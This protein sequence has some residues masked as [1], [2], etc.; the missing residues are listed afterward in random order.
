MTVGLN[1][2][3]SA[4]ELGY[5]IYRQRFT[6]YFKPKPS[7][8][9]KN[10][11]FRTPPN[12]PRHEIS[13]SFTVS[14][15][16][17]EKWFVYYVEAIAQFSKH[18]GLS[19]KLCSKLLV[20]SARLCR[21]IQVSSTAR[22]GDLLYQ[23]FVLSYIVSFQSLHHSEIPLERWSK[24]SSYPT[25]TLAKMLM[26]FTR[27][28]TEKDLV[29]VATM[30]H[31]PTLLD[32]RKNYKTLH[33][34]NVNG[35]IIRGSVQKPVVNF[36]Y[37]FAGTVVYLFACRF[38]PIHSKFFMEKIVPLKVIESQPPAFELVLP[39]AK[40]K[41]WYPCFLGMVFKCLWNIQ[42]EPH[43]VLFA[44]LYVGRYL[45][46]VGNFIQQGRHQLLYQ[47]FVSA[48]L[49]AQNTFGQ[50]SPIFS[51]WSAHTGYTMEDLQRMEIA[52]LN[53]LNWWTGVE[54]VEYQAF[55]T[56][57][58]LFKYF[59]LS[60]AEETLVDPSKLEYL[61]TVAQ[62]HELNLLD[63]VENHLAKNF[64]ASPLEIPIDEVRNIA[65]I[66]HNVNN[67]VILH[68]WK[69]PQHIASLEKV[70]EYAKTRVNVT[71]LMI[72][73]DLTVAEEL[74]ITA[75][76]LVMPDNVIY[77]PKAEG[78]F[79]LVLENIK[80]PAF[81]FTVYV[82]EDIITH[83]GPSFDCENFE[84][85]L[86]Q[87]ISTIPCVHNHWSSP[88]VGQPVDIK[89][90]LGTVEFFDGVVDICDN[91]VIRIA[92]DLGPDWKEFSRLSLLFGNVSFISAQIGDLPPI[93]EDRQIIKVRDV[94][95]AFKLLWRVLEY[96]CI[97]S[98]LFI[99]GF[100]VV[101]VGSCH[102]LEDHIRKEIQK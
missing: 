23:I 36:D 75:C 76:D 61:Q 49:A 90:I 69:Y 82:H 67:K 9:R 47:L 74:V 95:K 53:R 10:R 70:A 72:Q 43:V 86:P 52:F 18:F 35:G 55:K 3:I 100:E 85:R 58:Q 13:N 102:Q 66:P 28:V 84:G 37:Q 89:Q 19:N 7:A 83:R 50:S 78:V 60:L 34:V 16:M 44:M 25:F 93:I 41:D 33:Y 14:P 4:E 98:Y 79:A 11:Y 57:V 68:Y 24:I 21:L 92:R 26:E 12:M 31:V 6:P 32:L 38:N 88:A 91:V 81:P 20:L 64:P 99:R 71:F 8:T 63:T 45:K 48:L 29:D 39:L 56:P 17:T 77:I 1:T 27:L 46:N 54:Y 80:A 40:A 42:P 96:N 59:R 5:I 62:N 73:V 15:F 2:D 30:A 22:P 101:Y 87:F 97:P 51:E 94:K 65:P